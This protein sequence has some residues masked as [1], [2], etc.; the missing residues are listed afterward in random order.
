[1]HFCAVVPKLETVAQRPPECNY[2]PQFNNYRM[3]QCNNTSRDNDLANTI[4]SEGPL[5]IIA[6]SS[7]LIQ[8][9]AGI[10]LICLFPVLGYKLSLLIIKCDG[11]LNQQG[12]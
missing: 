11:D 3:T 6:N 4:I 1:M 2:T 10:Q 5:V 12:K 7:P 8:T 9:P